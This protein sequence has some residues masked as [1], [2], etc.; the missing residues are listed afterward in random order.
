MRITYLHQYFNTPDMSGGTR[1]YEMARRLVAR[2]HQVNMVTSWRDHC[3][4]RGWVETQE[5]AIRVHWLPV[6]YSN[7]MSYSQ[8]LQAFA[9]FACGAA[10]KA[11]TLKTD[12]V[13]ATSTPLS[14]AL[15]AVFASKK[16]RVPMVFEVRDLW[17]ALPIAIGALNNPALQ[18]LARRLESFAYLHSEAVVALSPQMRD[19]IVSAGYPEDRIAVIPNSSDNDDFRTDPKAGETFRA[20]YSW[21]GS[22][23]L[24]VYT[25]TFGRINGVSY[26]VDIAKELILIDPDIRILLIGD[27][28]ER[29]VILTKANREG[30]YGKNLFIENMIAK[31]DIPSLLAAANMATSLFI[32]LPEMRANS[33]NKFFDALASGTPVLLNYGGWQAELIR[34][35][36]AGIV[37]W[38]LSAQEGAKKVAR[39]LRDEEWLL[40]ASASAR[41]VAE[42]LFDRD[43]LASQLEKV[44]LSAIKREGGTSK[45]IAPGNFLEELSHLI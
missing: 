34:S 18:Y 23:P 31:R 32:D 1:S 12:V 13:F 21:L 26:L 4:G 10:T 45:S 42:N 27:G 40:K 16:L 37:T 41:K 7:K 43:K 30:V 28:L 33:A 44:L 15:P 22:R 5:A 2:G 36:G 39:C 29:E 17:P 3:E 20:R 6:P 9:R 14:I 35:S 11:A 24:L 38:G 19:G 25:G 8:R